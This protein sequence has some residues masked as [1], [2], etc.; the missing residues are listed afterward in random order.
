MRKK[1]IAW[2]LLL[3]IS[4]FIIPK[5]IIHDFFGHKD[6]VCYWH[7]GAFVEKQHHHCEILKYNTPVNWTPEKFVFQNIQF[8]QAGILIYNEIIIYLK[9]NY[10]TY[11]RAPP[12][13]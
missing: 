12:I 3:T 13:F 9:N 7:K 4:V 2:F 10:H 5:E 6:T 11:L 8:S 1:I